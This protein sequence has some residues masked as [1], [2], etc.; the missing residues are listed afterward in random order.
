MIL[1]GPKKDFGAITFRLNNQHVLSDNM[2]KVE[3]IFRKY[4]PDYPIISGY[5]DEADA[6]KFEE[7]KRTGIQSA[8][9][10]GLAILISCMGLFALAA[11]MA[12]NRI[13]EIG[14]RKVL[15]ASVSGITLLLS[16]DFVKLI[17]ISFG[18][19]SPVAWRLMH[20]WLE[21]YTYRVNIGWLVFVITGLLS[22]GIAI[23][24]VSF[25][26][27]KAALSNPAISLRSD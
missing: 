20:S 10:G 12:E 2:K 17:L 19:A 18:I 21:N 25:Q 7:E 26:A 16:K 14:I 5:V 1:Q 3:T 11:Y 4:I 15:G 23:A 27:V 9:F 8:L 24:T 13:K 22:L 6:K